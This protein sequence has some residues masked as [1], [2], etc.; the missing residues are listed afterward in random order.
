LNGCH[1]TGTTGPG[2]AGPAS[3][4]AEPPPITVTGMTALFWLEPIQKG[5]TL[6]AVRIWDLVAGSCEGL[7]QHPDELA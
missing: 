5:R 7:F 4:G 1:S 6:Y 3:P 2:N